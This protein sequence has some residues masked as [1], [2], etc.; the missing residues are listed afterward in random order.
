MPETFL[1]RVIFFF[2][3]TSIYR[4]KKIIAFLFLENSSNS[5]G[6]P[7]NPHLDNATYT[8][9]SKHDKRQI[10]T[11]RLQGEEQKSLQFK[12]AARVRVEAGRGAIVTLPRD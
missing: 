4:V 6:L 9:L 8:L 5:D 7:V 1:F 12:Q 3:L 2:S 10:P 11:V